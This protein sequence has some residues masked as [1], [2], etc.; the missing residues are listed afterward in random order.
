MHCG[1]EA[2]SLPLDELW[3]ITGPSSPGTIIEL[4]AFKYFGQMQSFGLVWMIIESVCTHYLH[5]WAL[6]KVVLGWCCKAKHWLCVGF[7][8][9]WQDKV[10]YWS[11]T[12]IL[13]IYE[14]KLYAS[15]T[16]YLSEIDQRRLY[17][18]FTTFSCSLPMPIDL[19][20]KS[21]AFENQSD[22]RVTFQYQF[23]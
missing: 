1:W 14:N 12:E 21:S 18:Y 11:V 8:C 3:Q 17:K 19:R 2:F 15:I 7:A 10:A 6:F 9:D 4:S 5:F 16:P 13:D 22:L 23:V 20:S